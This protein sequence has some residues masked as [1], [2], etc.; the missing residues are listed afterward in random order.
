MKNFILKSGINPAIKGGAVAITKTI[1]I[2]I[3]TTGD[4]I[5]IQN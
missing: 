4:L 2:G 1:T 5:D 3:F